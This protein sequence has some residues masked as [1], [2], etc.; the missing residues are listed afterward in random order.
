MKQ[1]AVEEAVGMVL[2]HD[3]TRIVP[4][5]FKGRAFRK[6]QH[7]RPED[8]PLLKDLGKEHLYVFELTEGW[9]HEDDAA[10]RIAR[11][12][13]GPGI[14][15]TNPAEG[16]VD[17]VASEPGLLKVD[18][19]ALSRINAVEEIVFSTLHTN[20]PVSAGRPV[21]G[22]R[23]IP[24]VTRE[25][26][27]ATVE[28]ICRG[29]PPVVSVRPYRPLSVGIV[30]TGSEVFSGRIEDRFGPVLK[31]KFS[32]LGSKVIAQVLVSDDIQKTVAAIRGFLNQGAGLVAVTGGM[33]VDPDDQTPAAIRAAG[34]TVVTYGA[35]AFPGA[36]FM[37]A[38]INDVPVLGLPGCVMYYRAS[39][40]DLVV[41]RILAG[42][43]L[44]RA[45]IVAMGHGGFCSGCLDC[46]YPFCAFGK[47]D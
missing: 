42:E 2:C 15:L 21:A 40:F 25:A 26:N 7:I 1:V 47:G 6:G 35:P 31:A 29:V 19:A 17:L 45:D 11:A 41:P 10:R 30:T 5:E 13:A 43:V 16:R 37:L 46:R 18:V 20:Q 4:G 12:A 24:L 22:T 32:E 34:C 3:I 9:V 8:I 39:I 38:Y 28:G 33:S 23:I 44:T 27:I 36:M 14:A